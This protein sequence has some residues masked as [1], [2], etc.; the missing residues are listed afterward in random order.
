M[1]SSIPS[2]NKSPTTTHLPIPPF[3]QIPNINNLRD[4]ALYPGGLPVTSPSSAGDQTREYKVRPGVLFRSGDVSRLTQEGWAAIKEIGIGCVFD[5]RSA[6]EVEKTK[7]GI[8]GQEWLGMMEKEGV[9]RVWCPV[10]EESDYSPAR[11]AERY[12]KYMAEG[13]E[14]F[15]EAYHDILTHAGPAYRSIFLYLAS[16]PLSQPSSSPIGALIH[17]TAGKDRTGLFLGLLLSFLNVPAPLIAREYHLS[18]LGLLSIRE[19]H[20]SKL[21]RSPGFLK[22]MAGKVSGREVSTEE[23]VD[24]VSKRGVHLGGEEKG[25]NRG[26]VWGDMGLGEDVRERVMQEGRKAAL[27]MVGAREE[28]MIRALEMVDREWGGVEGYMRKVC[29]LG[30]RELE[31]LRRV[32]VVRD[33]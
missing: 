1:A 12:M 25:G 22:F 20:V 26:D 23:M 13:V 11:L 28:A 29:G 16:L 15:A 32:L 5:L 24:L 18:E 3:Y 9:K 4:A 8:D 33:E 27:R 19:E 14:G 10:F 21:M 31:G 30:D 17:C 2:T 7:L 6:P